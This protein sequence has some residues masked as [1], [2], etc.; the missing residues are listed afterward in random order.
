MA[1]AFEKLTPEQRTKAKVVTRM[2]NSNLACVLSLPV[3]R[4]IVWLAAANSLL[5]AK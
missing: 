5:A 3:N 2:A 1:A 4:Q